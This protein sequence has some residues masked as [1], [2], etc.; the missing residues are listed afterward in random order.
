MRKDCAATIRSR[1]LKILQV[2]G[3]HI[4]ACVQLT[5]LRICVVYY[6]MIDWS[7]FMTTRP[8]NLQRLDVIPR[9]SESRSEF[10]LQ[11]VRVTGPTPVIRYHRT[12]EVV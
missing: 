11:V 3:A 2:C 7:V 4:E 10:A 12:L 8:E 6:E 1:S 9:I 5:F